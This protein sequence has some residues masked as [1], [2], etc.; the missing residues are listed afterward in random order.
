MYL[1]SGT[2]YYII[3]FPN[4]VVYTQSGL[5]IKNPNIKIRLLTYPE[6]SKLQ[7]LIESGIT[8]SE[9]NEEI[10]TACYL[11]LLGFEEETLLLDETPYLVETVG[12]KLY[13]ES[14]KI[15]SD[16]P[17]YFNSCLNNFNVFDIWCGI[18]ANVLNLNFDEVCLKPVNE[19]IRLYSIAYMVSNKT[20]QPIA[21]EEQS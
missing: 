18:I 14:I 17:R 11:G 19:I 20:I 9:I 2:N 8:L 5:T 6:L 12:L 1:Q 3:P 4:V 13:E 7:V 21:L 16:P 10:F 15:V